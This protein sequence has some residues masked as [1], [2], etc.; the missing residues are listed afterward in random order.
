MLIR[1]FGSL[2]G[3][4]DANQNKLEEIQGMGSMLATLI[5]LVK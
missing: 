1:R 5:G 2:S 3:V 4:L